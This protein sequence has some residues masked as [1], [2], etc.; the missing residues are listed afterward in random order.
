MCTCIL[1][2]LPTAMDCPG[3]ACGRAERCVPLRTFRPRP[4]P[5]WLCFTVSRY[6]TSAH[7]RQVWRT[8]S[9]A[10]SEPYQLVWTCGFLFLEQYPHPLLCGP[11]LRCLTEVPSEMSLY[12]QPSNVSQSMAHARQVCRTDSDASS[13]PYQIVFT[14]CF[15]FW[16]QYSHPLLCCPH[17]R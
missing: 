1:R 12:I 7:A 4:S 16:E 5:P 10:S 17:L 2:V 9:D 13:E 6:L 8:A 11:H 15:L 14:C 3:F